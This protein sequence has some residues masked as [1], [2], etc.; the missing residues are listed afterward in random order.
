LACKRFHRYGFH[1]R[2]AGKNWFR[3]LLVLSHFLLSTSAVSFPVAYGTRF[4]ERNFSAIGEIVFPVIEVSVS[5]VY[6]SIV[7]HYY[8]NKIK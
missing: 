2:K 7:K 1:G 3:I 5:S 6:L 4:L 8:F